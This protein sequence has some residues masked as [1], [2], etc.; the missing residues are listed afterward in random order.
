[1]TVA[2]KKHLGFEIFTLCFV[3]SF[4][5]TLRY[6]RYMCDAVNIVKIHSHNIILDRSEGIKIRLK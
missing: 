2:I 3:L 5:G 6:W 1:M 4:N